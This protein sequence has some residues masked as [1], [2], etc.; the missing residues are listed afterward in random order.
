MDTSSTPYFV[1]SKHSTDLKDSP[2]KTMAVILRVIFPIWAIVFIFSGLLINF[3]Q[4]IC[5]LTI[6]KLSLKI[7][8]LIN[9]GLNYSLQSQLVFW[10][11]L[12]GGQ[13]RI[14]YADDETKLLVGK[15]NALLIANHSSELD[16]LLPLV[17]AVHH[18]C[19]AV[20]NSIVP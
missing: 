16:W 17:Q 12:S 19:L 11:Q 3:L 15:E 7:Y 14:F 9:G 20:S 18:D 1:H 13:L 5:Y 10:F 2:I 6:K 8:K 4:F